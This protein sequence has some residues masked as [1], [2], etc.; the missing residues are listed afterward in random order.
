MGELMKRIQSLKTEAPK[1]RKGGVVVENVETLV[2]KLRN[3]AKVI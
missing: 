2:E 1:Q 3:E